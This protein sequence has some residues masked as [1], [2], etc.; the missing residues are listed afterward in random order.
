MEKAIAQVFERSL[1]FRARK[2]RISLS[3][4]LANRPNK[5]ET[6]PFNNFYLSTRKYRGYSTQDV[7]LNSDR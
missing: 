7:Q 2:K 1:F 4:S 5:Q 6:A 3:T